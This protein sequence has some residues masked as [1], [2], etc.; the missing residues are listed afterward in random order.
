M[1]RTTSIALLLLATTAHAETPAVRGGMP[2]ISGGLELGIALATSTAVGE[3][4]GDVPADDFIGRSANLEIKIGHRITPNLAVA[5]YSA[6]ALAERNTMGRDVYTGSAG[7]VA[8]LHFRPQTNVDPFVSF[9]GGVAAM[10]VSQN[11]RSLD[12]GV[13]LARLQTG[14]DFRVSPDFAIAPVIG[15]S[16]VQYGAHKSPMREFA[17]IDDKGVN[18]TL[19]AGIAGR[20]NAF[21][22]RK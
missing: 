15:M 12:V 13:E 22:S 16:V 7:V 4:G 21:G 11:G 3:L 5:F 19:S 2:A 17:E 6:A 18:W 14:I 20:F 10:L 8:D 1:L 9:G